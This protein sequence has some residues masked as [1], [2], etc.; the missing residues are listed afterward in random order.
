MSYRILLVVLLV[1]IL[2]GT[3]AFAQS[4]SVCE[5][6]PLEDRMPEI[7]ASMAGKA[8]VWLVD[9]SFGMWSGPDSLMKSV[10]VLSRDV[11][12]DLVVEGRRL[13]RPEAMRFQAAPAG[14]PIER[15]VVADARNHS[16]TPGG[17]TPEIMERYAF[18][19]M[20][21][22]YPSPG[23]WE[24]NVRLGPFETRIVVEQLD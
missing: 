3:D 7:I 23:C 22:V 2:L 12:G 16:V 19:M 14:S 6:T 5:A 15:V 8:P 9:G 18:V 24:I 1:G 11:A 17:A 20:Y 13:D 10:W 21:L 4:E